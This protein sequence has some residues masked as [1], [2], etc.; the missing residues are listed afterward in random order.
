MTMTNKINISFSFDKNY[1]KPALVAISSLLDAGNRDGCS[2]NIFC[3]IKGDVTTE[4]QKEIELDVK[5]KSAESEVFFLN[6]ESYF[7]D[8]YVSRGVTTAVYSRLILDKL[9]PQEDKIIYADVDMLIRDSLKSVW[10]M[11]LSKYYLA[12][13]KDVSAN[14]KERRTYLCEN[15]VYWNTELKNVH[16]NYFNSG[17]LVLNLVKI[18]NLDL[19]EQI[20]D[21]SKREHLY[22]DQDLFNIL[23]SAAGR[24]VLTLPAKYNFKPKHMESYHTSI[25]EGIFTQ[26]EVDEAQKNPAI[27]HYTGEKP[28]NNPNV[29]AANLWWDY[30]RENTPY[31][32][33]FKDLLPKVEANKKEYKTRI[34]ILGFDIF[35]K[36]KKENKRIYKILGIK[37]IIKKSPHKLHRSNLI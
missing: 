27:I 4:I 20:D 34:H 14:T 6:V 15:Y 11:D 16:K 5:E 29:C 1:Y 33:Y 2:Y 32:Q 22:W 17:L 37:F 23:Y 13:V 35:S 3:L 30:V 18:R 24:P 12:A 10:E 36:R 25:N 19:T 7:K 9:L 8:A 21:L 26:D 31:Y 28:W